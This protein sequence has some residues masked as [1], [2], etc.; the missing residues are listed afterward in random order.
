MQLY[1]TRNQVDQNTPLIHSPT[2]TGSG[3]S[4]I[5]LKSQ[6]FKSQQLIQNLHWKRKLTII[7]QFFLVTFTICLIFYLLYLLVKIIFS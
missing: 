4:S 1:K 3:I 2:S 5:T 6:Q 7:F